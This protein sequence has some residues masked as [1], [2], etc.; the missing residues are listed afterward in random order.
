MRLTEL[1]S[2]RERLTGLTLSQA[3]AVNGWSS[4][5]LLAAFVDDAVRSSIQTR[6][7]G[8]TSR[9]T[10]SLVMALVDRSCSADPLSCR[11][12]STIRIVHALT[13]TDG[14]RF[15]FNGGAPYD[16]GSGAPFLA[17]PTLLPSV[18][19]LDRGSFAAIGFVTSVNRVYV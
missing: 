1:A 15:H 4:L 18:G 5:A 2:T 8:G 9:T 6:R 7:Q 11:F 16:D 17:P 19:A 3:K 12:A 14:W 10:D 13:G